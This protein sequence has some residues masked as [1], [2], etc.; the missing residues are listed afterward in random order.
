MGPLPTEG[1]SA[2]P[3]YQSH[4]VFFGGA[5]AIQ[6]ELAN[7]QKNREYVGG[8]SSF[9]TGGYH[10]V[11]GDGSVRFISTNVSPSVL[12]NLTHRADGEMPDDF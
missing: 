8:P 10:V 4:A 5:A 3:L 7:L 9:H 12:R 1:A 2:E 6:Q 11:I